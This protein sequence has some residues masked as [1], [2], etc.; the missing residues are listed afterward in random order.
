MGGAAEEQHLGW[1]TSQN[2]RPVAGRLPTA[3]VEERTG[4]GEG[5]H[6]AKD[7]ASCAVLRPGIM[8]VGPWP[9]AMLLWQ[10]CQIA[11]PIGAGRYG[12]ES[13]AN[14]HHRA[15]VFERRLNS[16]L[17]KCVPNLKVLIFNILSIIR[18]IVLAGY[19]QI[20]NCKLQIAKLVRSTSHAR[21]SGYLCPL[22]TSSAMDCSTIFMKS[23]PI[24]SHT[25]AMHSGMPL[26]ISMPG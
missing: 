9:I 24:T 13:D 6:C 25:M 26:R 14:G 19:L 18:I 21:H 7:S 10:P 4:S 5:G 2:K 20:A 22:A 12:G 15:L 3:G 8:P 11:R 23:G 17:S 16:H 1:T